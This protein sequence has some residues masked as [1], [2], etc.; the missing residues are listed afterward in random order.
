MPELNIPN[1]DQVELMP[2]RLDP[3]TYVVNIQEEPALKTGTNKK[4]GASQQYLEVKMTVIEGPQQEHPDPN[5]GAT[6]PVGRGHRDWVFL[7][8]GAYFRVKQLLVAFGLLSK[9]DKTSPMAQGKINT[10]SLVGAR[11]TIKISKEIDKESQ[12]EYTRTEYVF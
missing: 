11:G 1:F 12:K 4:T 10:Q 9:D 7:V 6:N 3:G 8:D 2:P 5:T